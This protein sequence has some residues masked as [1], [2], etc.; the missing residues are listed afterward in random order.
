MSG[1]MKG[2]D[3]IRVYLAIVKLHDTP[4]NGYV[5]YYVCYVSLE[6]FQF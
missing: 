6:V 5:L 1:E 2:F 4:W 3:K